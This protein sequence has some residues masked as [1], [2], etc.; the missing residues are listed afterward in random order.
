MVDTIG[1]IRV[2]S[3]LMLGRPYL[4]GGLSSGELRSRITCALNVLGCIGV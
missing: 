2:S 3:L 4:C 1:C